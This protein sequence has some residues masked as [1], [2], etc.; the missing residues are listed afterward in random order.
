MLQI[1]VDNKTSPTR[2]VKMPA[3]FSGGLS[4]AFENT[5][6]IEQRIPVTKVAK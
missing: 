3:I 4:P 5:R 6:L 2:D 1:N